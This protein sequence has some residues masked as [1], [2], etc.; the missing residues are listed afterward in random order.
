MIDVETIDEAFDFVVQFL[1][2]FSEK[3]E[4][5]ERGALNFYFDS[6]WLE[7][8]INDIRVLGARRCFEIEVG[9]VEESDRIILRLPNDVNVSVS[10]DLDVD[11]ESDA[12]STR[13]IARGPVSKIRVSKTSKTLIIYAWR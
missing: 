6:K 9:R 12:D 13:V 3:Y 5:E 2:R 8:G 7:I 1:S 4:K 10:A 11:F